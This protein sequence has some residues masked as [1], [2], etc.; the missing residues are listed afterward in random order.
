MRRRGFTLLEVIVSLVVLTT[1]LVMVMEAFTVGLRASAAA[2][3]RTMAALLLQDKMEELKKEPLLTAGS[4][5]GDFGEDFADYNWRV[6]ISETET[7]GLV[8]V[9][10]TVMW[11][12]RRGED[13]LGLITLARGGQA[14][15]DRLEEREA[16]SG[17]GGLQ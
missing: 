11:E 16:Q 6:D 14:V 13:E 12:G 8:H 1:G 5:E 2:D 10:V 3:R 9:E 15:Q 17:A 4:D 7:P